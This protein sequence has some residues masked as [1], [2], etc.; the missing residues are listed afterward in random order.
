MFVGSNPASFSPKVAAAT[1]A[2]NS[3]P[4][5]Q[6]ACTHRLTSVE[7]Q[8]IL[9][10][11][12]EAWR[13]YAFD[14]NVASIEHRAVSTAEKGEQFRRCPAERCNYIFQWNNS[15]GHST[16]QFDSIV[17]VARHRFVYGARPMV[18]TWDQVM[19]DSR[20][21]HDRISSSGSP[22]NARNSSNG[23]SQIIKPILAS[24]ISWTT[25][26]R[27]E[28]PALVQSVTGSLPKMVDVIT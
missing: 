1:N 27:Q 25:N 14:A 17:P 28:Q 16:T 3:I 5:P 11:D 15:G 24:R 10:N 13:Q 18:G 21:T 9:H 26:G 22:R 23:K 4:C 19:R 12:V 20:A 2:W 7:I 8:Y 6:E